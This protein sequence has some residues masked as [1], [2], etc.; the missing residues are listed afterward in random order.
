M[1]PSQN[2]GI[3]HGWSHK[4]NPPH[5]KGQDGVNQIVP[6]RAGTTTARSLTHLKLSTSIVMVITT[7]IAEK[8]GKIYT[9][10]I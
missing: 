1:I 9:K 7:V 2:Y 10:A 8:T 4:F 5:C 3:I 6:S